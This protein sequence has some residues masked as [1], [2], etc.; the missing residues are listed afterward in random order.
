MYRARVPKQLIRVL[1]V[2]A[3][4]D[5]RAR[6]EALLA[7]VPRF[8]VFTARDLAEAVEIVERGSPQVVLLELD[9]PDSQGLDTLERLRGIAPRVPMVVLTPALNDRLPTAVLAAGAQDC[10]EEAELSA[11]LL[12]RSLRYAV[13]R[14]R[15]AGQVRASRSRAA[16][17]GKGEG[18]ARLAG[19]LAHDFNDQLTVIESSAAL[20]LRDT[21]ATSPQHEELAAILGAARRAGQLT[22]QLLAL[23]RG[24][25][26]GQTAVDATA[27]A[28]GMDALLGRLVGPGVRLEVHVAP[29][30]LLVPG[31]PGQLEHVLSQLVAHAREAVGEQGHIALTVRAAEAEDQP[32]F[33]ELGLSPSAAHVLIAVEHDGRGLDEIGQRRLFEPYFRPE[34]FSSGIGLAAAQAIV[35]QFGGRIALE[36]AEG[37][38]TTFWILLP[39]AAPLPAPSPEPA[40]LATRLGRTVLVVEDEGMVRRSVRRILEQSGFE[41]VEAASGSEALAVGRDRGDD[42]GLVITDVLMPDMNGVETARALTPYCRGAPVLFV[43][44]QGDGAVEGARLDVRSAFIAKPFNPD[45]LVAR[46][47]GLLP[48]R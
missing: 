44:G 30:P 7:E 21:P 5:R 33:D 27:I 34:G 46:V 31:A 41:V 15:L 36:S 4:G 8:G 10:L 43:S 22:S 2:K 47:E 38:G 20:L 32:L 40:F 17:L 25:A 35:T 1:L 13:A 26:P 12:G 28:A 18:V 19:G 6:I 9:L 3:E 14:E 24:R 42:I 16:Q 23:S 37:G 45:D 11:E 48:R 29:G 39:Q